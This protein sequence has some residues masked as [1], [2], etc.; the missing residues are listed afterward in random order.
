[1]LNGA[2][3]AVSLAPGAARPCVCAV[4]QAGRR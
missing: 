2:R 4:R 1:M 3:H